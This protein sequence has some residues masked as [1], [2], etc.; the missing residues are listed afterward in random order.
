MCSKCSPTSIRS[1][2]EVLAL[3]NQFGSSHPGSLLKFP[4]SSLKLLLSRINQSKKAVPTIQ[5]H[6]NNN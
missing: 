3:V 2:S 5:H 6:N 4:G 1:L